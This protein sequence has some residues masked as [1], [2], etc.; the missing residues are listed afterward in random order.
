MHTSLSRRR[1]LRQIGSVLLWGLG[2]SGAFL[3]ALLV[4][5]AVTQRFGLVNAVVDWGGGAGDFPWIGTVGLAAAVP[6]VAVV[7]AI[8]TR[9]AMGSRPR[10]RL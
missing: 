10:V 7:L 1:R 2:V 5:F 6:F 9:V 4:L 8:W 3:G